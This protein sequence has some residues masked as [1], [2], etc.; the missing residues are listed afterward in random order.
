MFLRLKQKQNKNKKLINVSF[1][2][3]KTYINIISKIYSVNKITK[4]KKK[5]QDL[6]KRK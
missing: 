6:I 3:H 2:V 1:T 4:A 5:S